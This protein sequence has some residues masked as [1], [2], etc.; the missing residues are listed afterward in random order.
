M[1]SAV[2]LLAAQPAPLPLVSGLKVVTVAA[3]GLFVGG[4]GLFM[5]GPMGIIGGYAKRYSLSSDEVARLHEALEMWPADQYERAVKEELVDILAA[6]ELAQMPPLTHEDCVRFRA[7]L[8]E[9]SA[10]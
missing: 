7:A 8:A 4:R 6:R 5:A 1:T 9:R 2:L 10:S 3:K